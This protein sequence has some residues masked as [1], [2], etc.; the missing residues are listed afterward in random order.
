M[1]MKRVEL[2]NLD[3]FE[4]VMAVATLQRYGRKIVNIGAYIPPNYRVAR[5]KKCLQYVAEAVMEAKRK[6]NEPTIIVAGDF[7]QWEVVGV[8][9]DFSDISEVQ[10]GPTRAG[11]SIDRI[12]INR[13]D[14]V[15]GYG[16]VPPLDA[17][18]SET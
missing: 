1:S 17:Q 10:V 16:T 5:G 9:Q 12:F 11:R 13:V 8:L 15:R 14:R 3:D 7:N 4:V 18:D 6:Y 2:P